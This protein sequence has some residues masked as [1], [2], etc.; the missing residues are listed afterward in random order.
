MYWKYQLCIVRACFALVIVL[1]CHTAHRQV[2][3]IPNGNRFGIECCLVR[4]HAST[5]AYIIFLSVCF[6]K[7][8]SYFF[9]LI[10]RKL[11]G[12]SR[13]TEWDTYVWQYWE[14]IWN[15][16]KFV[17]AS[18]NNNNNVFCPNSACPKMSWNMTNSTTLN[19]WIPMNSM[20]NRED[21]LTS[22]PRIYFVISHNGFKPE[23]CFDLLVVYNFVQC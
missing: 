23:V 21:N 19:E 16:I 1:K 18:L 15:L 14:F 6:Q 2:I 3:G 7:L 11:K 22:K 5:C 17:T 4:R 13:K 20:N 9:L 8:T 12:L 10:K